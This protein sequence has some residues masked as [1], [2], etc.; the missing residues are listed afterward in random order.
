MSSFFKDF[1]DWLC[2]LD[3]RE[4]L[5]YT[6]QQVLCMEKRSK[7]DI[8][9]KILNISKYSTNLTANFAEHR[10]SPQAGSAPFLDILTGSQAA[11]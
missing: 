5:W 10:K 8:Y 11:H 1:K 6:L 2:L 7:T 4:E 3:Q 9:W